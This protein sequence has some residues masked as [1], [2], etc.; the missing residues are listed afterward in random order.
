MN[1]N[2]KNCLAQLHNQGVHHVALCQ[3]DQALHDY[4]VM[5]QEILVKQAAEISQSV[6]QVQDKYAQELWEL[7]QDYAVYV[8]MI[9]PSGGSHD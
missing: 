7:E 6:K 9:T 4:Y 2:L 5:R 3:P 8:S 1:D